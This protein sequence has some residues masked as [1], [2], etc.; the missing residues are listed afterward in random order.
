MNITRPANLIL[1]LS[2]LLLIMDCATFKTDMQGK[3]ELS[4]E[5]FYDAERVSVLFFFSHYRQTVGYDA[6]PKLDE[7]RERISG[8]DEFF[9]DAL[10][11]LSNIEN[12]STYTQFASDVNDSRR[13]MARD[14]LMTA[15]DFVVKMKFMREKSFARHFLANLVST[16]SLTLV[17]MPYSYSYAVAVDIFDAEGHLLHSYARE[18][19][20]TKWV[21]TALIFVYPFHPERR[22][23]EELYVAFMHD[24]FK[25]IETEQVLKKE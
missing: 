12:Y 23:K 5:K 18:A 3:F 24:I 2:M 17:P 9:F 13:R 25:Q 11:E 22:K 4:P 10:N 7:Q 21:Q 6:I 14:S 1:S 19:G 15:H 16:F 20:L 8:F